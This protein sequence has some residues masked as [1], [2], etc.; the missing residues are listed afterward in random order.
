MTTATLRRWSWVAMTVLALLTVLVSARYLT[1]DPDTFL[2]E[3]RAVYLA[4]LLPLALHVG[5]GVVAMAL[6]PWQFRP[7][8]RERRPRLHRVL[9]RLYLLAVLVTGASGLVLAPRAMVGPIA[10]AGFAVL[11]VLLLW[12]S[13]AGFAAVRRG[14]VPRH[15]V[16]MIRSYALVFAAATLRVWLPVADALGVPFEQAYATAGW[17]CWLINLV[18]A[19]WLVG[20][21]RASAAGRPRPTGPTAPQDAAPAGRASAAG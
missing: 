20:R 12:S 5:G 14:A 16:W 21:Y 2:P 17:T 3:Q 10:P 1:L 4:N 9:G 6:G 18:V 19:E 8:L 7:A 15:R 13:A 11:G